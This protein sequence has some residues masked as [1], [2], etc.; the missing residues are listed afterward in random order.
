[1][2]KLL[3]VF[4]LI[5][6]IGSLELGYHEKFMNLTK[7]MLEECKKVQWNRWLNPPPNSDWRNPIIMENEKIIPKPLT[8]PGPEGIVET[9]VSKPKC[10]LYYPGEWSARFWGS[11]YSRMGWQQY[12]ELIELCKESIEKHLGCQFEIELVNNITLKNY[13]SR[14]DIEYMDQYPNSDDKYNYMKYSLLECQG[15]LWMPLDSIAFKPIEFQG[16]EVV[17][18]GNG[19]M[20]IGLWKDDIYLNDSVI[21]GNS[22]NSLFTHMKSVAK[23]RMCQY[24]R[25]SQVI[26]YYKKLLSSLIGKLK[27]EGEIMHFDLRN[28]QDGRRDK[29]NNWID[30]SNFFSE[31]YTVVNTPNN[32]WFI[33][34]MTSEWKDLREYQYIFRLSKEQILQSNLWF[35]KL[36]RV[37]MDNTPI[38]VSQ[39]EFKEWYLDEYNLQDQNMLPVKGNNLNQFYMAPDNMVPK[40][41][42]G[43]IYP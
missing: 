32:V 28:N 29:L 34:L 9:F 24:S 12:P 7:N 13:M 38:V 22:Y 2:Y 14:E 6:L 35:A 26:N 5:I 20:T 21:A 30:E 33:T 11:F 27:M 4:I 36:I 1:M 41:P 17:F 40:Q 19:I 3:I 25:S 23:T 39:T 10:W 18:N 15:G 31:N 8:F 16:K 37:S 43:E 42:Y